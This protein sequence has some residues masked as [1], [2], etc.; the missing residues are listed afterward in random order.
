MEET[1]VEEPSV[2]NHECTDKSEMQEHQLDDEECHAPLATPEVVSFHTKI[3]I[4]A[5]PYCLLRRS[6]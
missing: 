3:H 4:I 2:T 6:G 1:S 5:F